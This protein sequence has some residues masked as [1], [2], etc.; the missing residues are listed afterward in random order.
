VV[1][2]VGGGGSA[3]KRRPDRISAMCRSKSIHK[4]EGPKRRQ[5]RDF[6]FKGGG[7]VCVGGAG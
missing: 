2:W 5:L 7:V 1:G 3:L 6:I 4:E